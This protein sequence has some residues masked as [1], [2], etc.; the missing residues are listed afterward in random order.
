MPYIMHLLKTLEISKDTGLKGY[1][2]K[3]L[4]EWRRSG[5]DS[6]SDYHNAKK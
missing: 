6:L 1:R 4:C 3:D 2:L 5:I